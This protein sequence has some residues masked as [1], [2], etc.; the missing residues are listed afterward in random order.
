MA[1]IPPVAIELSIDMRRRECGYY[2]STP[3]ADEDLGDS[4]DFR[5]RTIHRA[6]VL[7]RFALDETLVTNADYATF[8]R[9]SGYQPRLRQN[10]LKH[11][12]HGHL[13]AGKEQH[14]VVYVDLDDARAYA[15]WAGKRL[16]TEEE[17]Q[18]AAQ[19]M[20]GRR[21]PWGEH[22]EP[23]RCN[24]GETGGT[25]P[26]KAFPQGRSPYGCY[27]MCGNVW[28]W[29]ESQRSDGHTRFCIIRGGA[30]FKASGSGWYA[31]GGPQ[32]VNFAG[33]FLLMWP[34]LD[35][36]GTIGFRCAID[37]EA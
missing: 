15:K 8:L 19:G 24:G 32:P 1:E 10:F 6:I 22:F 12:Q 20:D 29:T 21:Y 13:P 3:P 18:F 34:G 5:V 4:Y 2:Q 16:P 30:F 31:D 17:W 23:G 35:R 28:E 27:D 26:V 37:L 11:W 36:C 14:P 25:T 33:K 9:A 7:R